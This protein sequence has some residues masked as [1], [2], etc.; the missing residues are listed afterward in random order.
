MSE[1]FISRQH[2]VQLIPIESENEKYAGRLKK[3]REELG[4][5]PFIVDSVENDVVNGRIVAQKTITV[6]GDNGN[7]VKV[8]GKFIAHC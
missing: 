3:L 6:V 5:G 2:I 7:L 1:R 4:A 8:P